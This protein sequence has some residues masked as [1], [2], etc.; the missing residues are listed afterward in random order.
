MFTL[1]FIKVAV[2]DVHNDGTEF[3][4]QDNEPAPYVAGAGA[5]SPSGIASYKPTDTSVNNR[6][7]TGPQLSPSQAE[8]KRALDIA[9]IGKIASTDPRDSGAYVGNASQGASTL[10]S[11]LKYKTGYN[12]I[13]EGVGYNGP[14]PPD[15][16]LVKSMKRFYKGAKK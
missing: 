5:M 13:T 3:K 7:K 4:I 8:K 16:K 14:K 9:T 6:P 10:A 11:Q 1:G 2:F 15:S 12:N